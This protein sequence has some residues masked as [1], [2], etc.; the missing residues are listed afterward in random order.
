MKKRRRSDEDFADEIGAHLANETDQLIADGLSPEEARNAALR[1]FGSVTRTRER[2]YEWRRIMLWEQFA[3]DLRYAWRGLAHSRAFVTNTVVTLASGMGLV[4]VVF[5]IFNAYV[6]RPFAVQDPYSLYLVEWHAKEASG[7]TFRWRDYEDFRSRADLFAGAIA[8]SRRTVTTGGSQMSVG[9]V[10]GNYFDS[11]GARVAL[12]RGL[13]DADARTPDSEPVVVLTD[14]SWSRLFDRDPTVIGRELDVNGVPLVVVGVMAPEFSGM[15]EVPRDAWV[16]ITMYRSL[17]GENPFDPSERRVQVTVRLRPDV[18]AARAQAAVVLEPFET[19]VRGRRD[20]VRAELMQHA[21]SVRLTWSGLALLSPV[22]IAFGL[23][24]VAASANASNVMLARANARHREIGIRLSIGASRGR[25]VRQLVTEGLLLALLAGTAGLALAGML[26]SA[27]TVVMVAMLP[28]TIAARV[29]IIPLHF[30]LRV[31]LFTCLLVGAVTV[32]FALLP[33]LQATRVTLTDALRGQLTSATRGGLTRSVLITGQVSVSLVLLIVATTILRNGVTIRGIDLGMQT[34]GVISVRENRGNKTLFRSSYEA[35]A[36]HAGLGSVAVAS[37][38]P[39]FGEA[40][41]VPLRQP[42]GMHFPSYAF[43]SPNYFDLLGISIVRGRG[44]TEQEAATEAPLLI[45]SAELAR[46]LWENDDPLGK[47]IRV[48]IEPPSR[49]GVGDTIR[50]M[51][52]V[53]ALNDAAVPMTVVG[54]A[55]DTVNG[56]VFQGVDNG[57]LYL[58]T[59]VN[60]TRASALLVRGRTSS[61]PLD[62]VRTALQRISPDAAA[63][64]ILPIDEMVQLQ[65][66]PMRA[67]SCIGTLLS[68]IALAF[69]I[70]GLYGVLTYTFGQRKQEIGIRMALGASTSAVERMVFAQSA[71]LASAGTV[72]GL[73]AGFAIMKLLSGFVRLTN[74]SV[75]DPLAFAVSVAMIGAAVA[76]AAFWPARRAGRLDPSAMLRADA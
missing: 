60:G 20:P 10:S 48:Y 69:S 4:L 64:D 13:V 2:F 19:R 56:F 44:F 17:L 5:T 16:P 23:V 71:N 57:H 61:L 52:S 74:V 55:S 63:F 43:V 46:R 53:G 54:V 50:E 35:L 24:L 47:T 3:H 59:N 49:R 21:T 75:V 1:H 28:P 18:T 40:P 39:L 41:R 31:V 68:A 36:G 67:A 51:R 14:A 37:R 58:P 11:L 25:I 6:L 15:D 76:L 70:S 62:A 27:G 8:E 38:S 65:L 29:R 30:D 73:I 32:L 26:R 42:D 33:A 9:F 12:G 45:V 72:L 34:A 7:S 22:F 66:F